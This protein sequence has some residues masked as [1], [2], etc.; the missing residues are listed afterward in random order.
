MSLLQDKVAI[1]TGAG[2]GIGK[3]TALL[4][5]E[6][7]AKVVVTDINE[8]NGN[9]V[10]EEIKATGGEAIFVKA[11]TSKV[12][13]SETT[14]NKAIESFGKLDVAVNNAGIGGP[15]QAVGEYDI[16]AWNKVININLNGVFYGLRYQIPAMVKNGGG[17]IINVASILGAVGF[18]NSSAYVAAKHGVV[19]LTKNAGL[20]YATKGVRVNAVGPAFIETPLVKSSLSDEAYNALANMHAMERLGQP[21]EVAELFLWLASDKASFATGAYYP[22]DG[23]Y[24]AK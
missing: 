23:G 19:G 4:F 18:A 16:D 2:S 14:V 21:K 20:E 13:D 12:E 8:E 1:V 10:V 6:N 11:D 5:A 15:T 7:G 17:S 9:K 24:L 22:I 3:S